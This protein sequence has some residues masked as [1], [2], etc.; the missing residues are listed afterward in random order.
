METLT[1]TGLESKD[2]PA[3]ASNAGIKGQAVV[4]FL[5]LQPLAFSTH[6]QALPRWQL[7]V[8]NPGSY[9]TVLLSASD[10]NSRELF[11]IQTSPA[12]SSKRFANAVSPSA[13]SP[14]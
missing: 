6:G 3:F 13:Y 12:L 14:V 10:S 1:K 8:L 4:A 9:P 5:F 7:T 2:L 11:M